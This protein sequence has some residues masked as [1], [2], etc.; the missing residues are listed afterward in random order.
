MYCGRDTDVAVVRIVAVVSGV[1]TLSADGVIRCWERTG[2]DD[3]YTYVCRRAVRTAVKSETYQLSA[4]TA[5]NAV[6]DLIVSGSGCGRIA[7]WSV[8]DAAP[9]IVTAAD[10]VCALYHADSADVEIS[11]VSITDDGALVVAACDCGRVHIARLVRG[12]GVSVGEV[13]SG[14][15]H[16][17]IVSAVRFVVSSDTAGF[18]L[19][20]GGFDCQII[21][22]RYDHS[23]AVVETVH[24]NTQGDQSATMTN[25]PFVYALAL[26]NAQIV[27]AALGNGAVMFVTKSNGVC[28]LH[29]VH[30]SAVIDI[31]CQRIQARGDRI[32]MIVVTAGNDRRIV[33][34]HVVLSLR[35][36]VAVVSASA[37]HDWLHQH[38]VNEILL[39]RDAQTIRVAD[40]TALV[41]A[42]RANIPA[43]FNPLSTQNAN[44]TTDNDVE[45]PQRISL[46]T[47]LTDSSPRR[48]RAHRQRRRTRR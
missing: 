48:S 42:V 25:P 38:K 13:K 16:T 10:A 45:T 20:S 47:P 29:D 27:A 7:V 12:S 28:A 39:E 21:R 6:D 1:L 15:L 22:R 3:T 18:T 34:T 43:S 31:R 35:R 4:A 40:T 9:L 37:L 2:D 30:R 24:T 46:T 11:D 8:D 5:L 23:F 32:G 36:S 41:T 19:V 17:S 33:V 44:D 14:P 26:V